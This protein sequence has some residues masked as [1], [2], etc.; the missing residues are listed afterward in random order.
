MM[1]GLGKQD[2]GLF[3]LRLQSLTYLAREVLGP[4]PTGFRHRLGLRELVELVDQRLA[5]VLPGLRSLQA[6]QGVFELVERVVRP[7]Q[8]LQLS[9]LGGQAL[10]DLPPECSDT[11]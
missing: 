9:L 7:A 10:G 6:C 3:Q 4:L 8:P 2:P 1:L 5:L 11:S